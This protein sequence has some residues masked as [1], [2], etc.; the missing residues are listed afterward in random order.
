MSRL[1]A[2]PLA[3]YRPLNMWN[4]EPGDIVFWAGIFSTWIGLIS[5][6]DSKAGNVE[7]IFGGLPALLVRMATSE[8]AKHTRVIPVSRI[9][10]SMAGT[11]AVLQLDK[12][13][14]ANIW[15]V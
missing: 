12:K 1:D 2:P 7:T 10:N 3:V 6:V 5:A 13:Q 9:Y 8:Y 4:P 11:F 15:Y 14:G